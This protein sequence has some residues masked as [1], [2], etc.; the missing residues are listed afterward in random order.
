MPK[1]RSAGI[2]IT[3][4]D[5]ATALELNA[6]VHD[7]LCGFILYVHPGYQMG[8]VHREICDTLNAFYIQ[9]KQK[10]SPRLIICMPPRSGKSEIVSRVFPA[11]LLGY[12]PDFQIIASSY[13]ADLTSRFN[14][15]V[16]RIMDGERFHRVFPNV[17]LKQRGNDPV[18]R[19]TSFF[20][21]PGHKGSYRSTG[22]G[23]GITGQGCD[24]LIIDDPVKDR[25]SA[26]SQTIRDATWDWFTSTAY[27][28]LNAGGGVIVMCTRWHLDDLVGR[29]LQSQEKWQLINYPAIAEHD[30]EHRKAGEALHPERYDLK[31]L[32][33]IKAAVGP[34]DWAALYQQH[35][36]PEG[37]AMFHSPGIEYLPAEKPPRFNQ[38]LGSWDMTFKDST[39]SDY[40]VGQVWGQT[41]AD[42]WLLDQVRGRWDFVKTLDVFQ[43]LAQKWPKVRRW[44]IE[45]KANGS[46]VISTL[47]H[48]VPGI[49][50][51]VPK[52]SKTARASAVTPFFEAGNVHVPAQA[53]WFSDFT[54][55]LLSFPAGAHDDQVDA[56]TQALNWFRGHRPA[57][58]HPNNL[59]KMRYQ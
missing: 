45:D 18:A 2:E 15:D 44:L 50:P 57:V 24:L 32:L 38:L 5:Q 35:P 56:L 11:W 23:G 37:G 8:W 41:G 14:R 58:I 46:A 55:E 34:S 25:A 31:E 29:L 40:V 7:Y 27:T 59:L 33:N 53:P 49:I 4:Q 47:K 12:D 19:T 10:Q 28:R 17:A 48:A 43:T 52:E 9:I 51:V 22:I 13:S 30:E 21:I 1:R 20:E 3:E 6:L 36:I 42:F 54:Q 26:A 39:G 16:Q